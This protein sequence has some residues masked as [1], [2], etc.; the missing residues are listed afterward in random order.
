MILSIYQIAIYLKIKPRFNTL[1]MGS[2]AKY[3]DR[4]DIL[5][6]EDNGTILIKEKWK[7]EWAN[8][9]NASKWTY[10][11]KKKFHNEVDNIVW[12][13]WGK[14]FYLYASGTSEFA[15]KNS[16]KRWDV[17]FDIQWVLSSTHWNVKV[18]KLPANYQGNPTS[19]VNWNKRF[20]NLDTKDTSLRKR[21]DNN[22]EYY[23]YPVSHEFGHT[24][25]N[26]NS[27]RKGMHSDEYKSSS[28]F[29]KDRSSLMNI[30]N[31]LRTR[32]LDYIII[33]LNTMIPN[34]KFG[35]YLP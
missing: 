26:N 10:S 35:F 33:Q 19:F 27:A 15:K 31:T 32:H 9:M 8:A 12:N 1:T 3:T 18:T 34:T 6:D 11:E 5:I 29:F 30:G 25:G 20:I 23:Q 14:R 22:K 21:V 13:T 4:M 7:Y 24:T 17:N 16:K 28:S 2:Y